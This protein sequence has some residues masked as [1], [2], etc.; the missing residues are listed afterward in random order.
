MGIATHLGPW[1]LGT[2]KNTTGTTAGTVR[3]IGAT[4]VVQFKTVSFTEGN[5]TSTAFALPAGSMI[6][7]IQFNCTTLFGAGTLT[8]SIGATPISA[9]FTLPTV[10]FGV[11]AVTFA[12]TAAAA[13]L[14]ANVGT[15]D[16]L[17][18][19]T[20]AGTPTLGTGNLIIA[21]VVRNPDGSYAPTAFTG[22]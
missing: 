18:T 11:S 8:V 3:N 21:Y 6:Q 4:P 10:N 19:Y 9:A 5:S 14:I 22:P 16:A 2:V 12:T 17:V 20:L 13:T 7:N 15:T 1:L